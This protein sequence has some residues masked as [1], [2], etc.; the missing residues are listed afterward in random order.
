[1]AKQPADGGLASLRNVRVLIE[2]E[3]RVP[4]HPFRYFRSDRG[5]EVFH[6]GLGGGAVVWPAGTVVLMTI[7]PQLVRLFS[8][9]ASSLPDGRPSRAMELLITGTAREECRRQAR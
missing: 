1:M 9:V 8:S 4:N 6:P 5:D 7:K 3:E 2:A